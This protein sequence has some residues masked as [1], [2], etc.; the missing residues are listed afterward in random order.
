MPDWPSWSPAAEADRRG[1]LTVD[2]L[3]ILRASSR[4]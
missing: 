2:I 1:F 3:R 4:M